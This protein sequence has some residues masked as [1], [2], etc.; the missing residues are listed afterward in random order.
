MKYQEKLEN[1][2]DHLFEHGLYVPSA[3]DRVHGKYKEVSLDTNSKVVMPFAEDKCYNSVML[4]TILTCLVKEGE[5]SL[6]YK[7]PP[8][9]GK[10]T[11]GELIGHFMFDTPVEEIQ[12]AMIYCHPEQTEEKMIARLNIADLMS[13]KE[14]VMAR[15]FIDSPVHILDEINRLPPDKTDIL[16]NM[17]DRRVVLYMD[18]LLKLKEGPLLVTRNY[19][20]AGNFIMTPP[21]VDRFDVS[22]NVSTP[23]GPS[24]EFILNRDDANLALKVE[25]DV[26]ITKEDRDKIWQEMKAMSFSKEAKN[27]MYYLASQINFC[28]RGASKYNTCA[29]AYMTKGNCKKKQPDALCKTPE[30]HY[31]QD[32]SVC[33]LTKNEFS[34]R[35]VRSLQKYSKAYAWFLG[36]KEVTVETVK[37][38]FPYVAS[39]RIVPTSTAEQQ[40]TGLP[41]DDTGISELILKTAEDGFKRAISKDGVFENYGAIVNAFEKVEK[42]EMTPD[43][44]INKVEVH[45]L[46]EISQHDDPIKYSLAVW[47]QKIHH[48]VF[49]KYKVKRK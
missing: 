7:G 12:N 45:G 46:A 43:D 18:K 9:C 24:L 27:Y 44:F 35:A 23:T 15:R 28:Q 5:G 29:P 33:R 48:Y 25:D 39:H 22:V 19:D 21:F 13:G 37:E 32:N 41:N 4:L 36:E 42:G 3:L 11:V 10:T 40:D 20:D 6:M 47:L 38:M 26:R 2:M 1:M 31:Y 8:G 34:I 30:C 17:V 14:T 49:T 16:Y